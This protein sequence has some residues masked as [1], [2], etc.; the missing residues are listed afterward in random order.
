MKSR[1]PKRTDKKLSELIAI[2]MKELRAVHGFSQEDLIEH[3]G[4]DI[5]HFENGS[6]NPT[7]ISLSSLC[8]FY[9]IT[10]SE[11]FEPMNYPPKDHK[12]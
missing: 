11:F 9:N 7:T 4:L 5:F 2:R 6:K 8:R 12:L 3:T 10:L 1:K